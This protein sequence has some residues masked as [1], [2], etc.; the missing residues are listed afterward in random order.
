MFAILGSFPQIHLQETLTY[1]T[2]G[3][4]NHR[5]KSALANS[6]FEDVFPIEN[7]DSPARHVSFRTGNC[8]G[9]HPQSLRFTSFVATLLGSAQLFL[10]TNS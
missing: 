4:Q 9:L 6:P 1:P 10:L 8:R 5:L 2:M 7:G 3:K